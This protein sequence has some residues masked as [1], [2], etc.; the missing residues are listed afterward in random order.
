MEKYYKFSVDLQLVF[1]DFKQTYNSIT[2][3]EICQGLEILNERE[4]I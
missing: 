1:I 3:N 4:Y 2:I